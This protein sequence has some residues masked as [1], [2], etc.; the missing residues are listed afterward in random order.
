MI[1]SKK[2]KVLRYTSDLYVKSSFPF[3]HT[4]NLEEAKNYYPFHEI[5]RTLIYWKYKIRVKPINLLSVSGKF[6][7]RMEV[8]TGGVKG[9]WNKLLLKIVRYLDEKRTSL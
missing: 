5:V 6:D 9:W 8:E 2:R 1:K 7:A 3:V 4:N